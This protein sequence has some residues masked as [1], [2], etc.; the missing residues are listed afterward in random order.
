MNIQ[1]KRRFDVFSKKYE[2]LN[3]DFRKFQ[4]RNYFAANVNKEHVFTDMQILSSQTLDNIC[5]HF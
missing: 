1:R 2:I 3:Y 4:I 5:N